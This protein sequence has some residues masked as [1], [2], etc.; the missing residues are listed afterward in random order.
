M[1]KKCHYE[2][3]NHI[4]Y[5]LWLFIALHTLL[6][7]LG[8]WFVRN[9]LPHDTLESITW[10]LQ[11]QWGY[12]KHPFLAAWLSAGV[13]HLFGSSEWVIYLLAQLTVS[14]SLIATWQL[15]KKIL[16]PL[17]AVI[18]TLI[19]DGVLFYNINSFHVDPDSLQLPLWALLSLFFYQ[20]LS[21]QWIRYWLTVGVITALCIMTKYQII[22][23][24]LPMTLFCFINTQA[25]V[26]FV[27]PGLYLAIGLA[28]L[29]LIPHA[30]WLLHHDFITIRYALGAPY[31]H[32]TKVHSH[33][34]A[35]TWYLIN[36]FA[37]VSG[38]FG[39]LWPFYGKERLSLQKIG[40]DQ[41]FIIFVCL[42]PVCLT[43]LF[44]FI[45]GDTV[46]PRWSSP[47]FS[48]LGILT[49]TILKPRI[50]PKQLKQWLV[51]LIT[52]SLL[53]W[54]IRIMTFNF[55]MHDKSDAYL[56]NKMM[57]NAFTKLWH[58]HYDSPLPYLG[59]AH[60]LVASIIPYTTDKP[61]PYFSFDDK[62][63]PWIK[64]QTL[65]KSGGLFVWDIGENYFWDAYSP[66][67]KTLPKTIKQHFPRLIKLGSYT[68][69]RLTPNAT[70]IKIG[71]ALLPPQV[72]L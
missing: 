37:Y 47:Y 1:K 7:T 17:H 33:F 53:L 31:N 39:L 32:Q 15:A 36:C 23:L 46:P 35:V 56:P 21:T 62:E 29:L 45:N 42:G 50:T 20:A 12:N 34:G 11:W 14:L 58:Q 72:S 4:T 57:A 63:N 40:F 60:Y 64:N 27:K 44:C 19:L 52:F 49:L 3:A 66:A 43:A 2:D 71:V 48:L 6:W 69:Y 59:G 8:P 25:R 28:L 61:Q 5:I 26:S 67:L 16:P 65:M 54:S 68:F 22:I 51:T 41:Q 13:Y 70:P 18:A 10:G 9:S 24:I 55:Y 30:S 38:L